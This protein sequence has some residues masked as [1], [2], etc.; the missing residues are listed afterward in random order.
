MKDTVRTRYRF[1]L[2]AVIL[3]AILSA[4]FAFLAGDMFSLTAEN[5]ESTLEFAQNAGTKDAAKA[6]K[7]AGL[8]KSTVCFRLYSALRGKN[9]YVAPGIYTVK[10]TAGY[11]GFIRALNTKAAER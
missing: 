8:I 7:S 9:L 3:A 1:W 11:D 5:G 6:L 2:C 4:F 10:N